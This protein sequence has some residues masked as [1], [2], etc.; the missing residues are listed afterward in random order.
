MRQRTRCE[1]KSL[2]NRSLA[3]AIAGAV[4]LLYRPAYAQPA[5]TGPA[6]IDKVRV[7][8]ELQNV[9][10]RKSSEIGNDEVYFL[11]VF[12]GTP[13]TD[14]M[15]SAEHSL[16]APVQ[17]SIT[18]PISINDK[19]QRDFSTGRVLFD[20]EV[21]RDGRVFGGLAGYE[22]D[23]SKD[24]RLRTQW[25]SSL[26]GYV[27][28]VAQDIRNRPYSGPRITGETML[29]GCDYDWEQTRKIYRNAPS[30]DTDD[31]LTNSGSLMFQA[32]G[33]AQENLDWVVKSKDWEYVVRYRIVRTPIETPPVVTIP[34]P[35]VPRPEPLPT[36]E[37]LKRFEG[38]WNTD[39]GE[40][41]LTIG[42]DGKLR[43]AAMRPSPSGIVAPHEKVE[44]WELSNATLLG[45][46]WQNTMGGIGWVQSTPTNNGNNFVGYYEQKYHNG[47]IDRKLWNGTR[48]IPLPAPAPPNTPPAPQPPPAPPLPA[49]PTP[50]QLA[51]LNRFAG[52]WA[53]NW[54]TLT[55]TREE[56]QLKGVVR[57]RDPI[58]GIEG[59]AETIVLN[60]SSDATRIE[61]PVTFGS[62]VMG[63]LSLTLGADGDTFSGIYQRGGDNP[64]SGRRIKDGTTSATAPQASTPDAQ[65]IPSTPTT[66]GNGNT[67]SGG[68]FRPLGDWSVQI[69]SIRV[70][71][72]NAIEVVAS[73]KNNS[74]NSLAL[75]ASNVDMIITDADGVGVRKTGNLYRVPQDPDMK[76]ELLS[77]NI[78]LEP[79]AHARTL[80]LFDLPKGMAPLKTLTIFGYSAKPL[81]YNISGLALPEPVEPVT[82]PVP[83]AV[84]GS[85]TFVSMGDYE[86]RFDGV[87]KDRNNKLWVFITCKNP[88]K[89]QW[90]GHP[91]FGLDV[92]IIDQDGITIEDEG[93]LYRA[94]GFD[95]DPRPIEHGIQIIPQDEATICYPINLPKGA[96]AK[97]LF[98]KHYGG[99][100]QIYDLPA[101]P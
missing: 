86:V 74:R 42:A 96:V 6:R 5:P 39:L 64:A 73:Y 95:P 47:T 35:T 38:K 100:S 84:G 83:G 68:S 52:K 29:R 22:E 69:E 67:S 60:A 75:S 7:Q 26:T 63:P 20:A 27:Q 41:T 55:L 79:S 10:C 57:R 88:S 13:Y 94:S 28:S 56:T 99:I 53:F 90:K 89:D 61:G 8:I 45:G 12:V 51:L 93:N 46:Q 21:A 34:I 16:Q 65:S 92:A 87:K 17:T 85:N 49:E 54:G 19:Q 82:L 2:L 3:L 18:T 97:Q 24:W 44:M 36:G 101:I 15:S 76:P 30:L 72:G 77:Q 9:Y 70:A 25:V 80:A 78:Q 91:G 71:R 23:E 81:T 43:G 14:V 48:A 4:A 59:N 98:I 32:E 50:S 62:T 58:S 40:L 1:C 33:P 66:A 11:S 37:L 31:R